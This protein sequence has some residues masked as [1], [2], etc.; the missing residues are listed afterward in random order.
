M[1]RLE[2]SEMLWVSGMGLQARRPH[3]MKGSLLMLLPLKLE[4]NLLEAKFFQ[5]LFLPF[6]AFN[7]SFVPVIPLADPLF[8][9]LGC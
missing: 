5:K 1:F 8:V 9:L 6:S 3:Q 7:T 2:A 4:N